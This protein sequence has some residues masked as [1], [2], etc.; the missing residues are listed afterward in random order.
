M[1]ATPISTEHVVDLARR[2]HAELGHKLS[3]EA[4]EAALAFELEQRGAQVVRQQP[5][6]LC[7]GSERLDFGFVAHILV[8]QAV[9]VRLGPLHRVDRDQE[10]WV[11][12]HLDLPGPRA[13]VLLDFLCPSLDVVTLPLCGGGA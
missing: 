12:E 5:L 10:I 1:E 8:D 13:G 9:V 6:G 7:H 11:L 4:Y 3:D 2:L